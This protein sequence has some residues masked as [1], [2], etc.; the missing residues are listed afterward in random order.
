MN[1]INLFKTWI[2]GVVKMTGI[3]KDDLD[4]VGNLA[5]FVG[6]YMKDFVS[7]ADSEARSK[8]FKNNIDIRHTLSKALQAS[9]NDLAQSIVPDDTKILEPKKITTIEQPKINPSFTVGSISQL[10]TPN[11]NIPNNTINK[12]AI[13][14][15][16]DQQLEFN[17]IDKK[18]EGIGSVRDVISHF[19]N[20]LDGI[21]ESIKLIKT[22]MVEIKANIPKKKKKNET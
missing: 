3:R 17:F 19:N 14:Y 2:K 5:G 11:D 9:E 13:N 16:E 7:K 8:L 22:F 12:Q 20:R 4:A 18:I 1:F 6:T 15:S 21:E 10:T